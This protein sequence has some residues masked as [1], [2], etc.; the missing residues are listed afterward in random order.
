[1]TDTQETDIMKNVFDNA[2][3]AVVFAARTQSAGRNSSGS[4]F[5]DGN[6]IYSYGRHFPIAKIVGDTVLITTRKNS[7][8][9]AR[10]VSHVRDAFRSTTLQTIYVE[11]V[12]AAGINEITANVKVM[13]DSI[14]DSKAKASRARK[15]KEFHE[16]D[17][18]AKSVNM[19]NYQTFIANIV[20]NAA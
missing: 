18:S 20:A 10:H 1:M 14:E 17:R 15:Y 5:F 9:T 16:R 3:V 8:T 2:S 6:I 19:Y 7:V 12:L 13:L 4:I 11:D